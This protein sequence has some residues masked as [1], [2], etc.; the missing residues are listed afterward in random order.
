MVTDFDTCSASGLR[1][2]SQTDC[3]AQRQRVTAQLL[4]SLQPKSKEEQQRQKTQKGEKPDG[5]SSVVKKHCTAARQERS[6]E[7]MSRVKKA[8]IKAVVKA[9]AADLKKGMTTDAAPGAARRAMT[10]HRILRAGR[11]VGREGGCT[12][13]CSVQKVPG[14]TPQRWEKI[15]SYVGRARPA[16]LKRVKAENS[17]GEED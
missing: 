2:F 8:D 11:C 14:G 12:A 17:I 4:Q 6:E 1:E 7:E 15:A 9:P 13:A 5:G 3:K 16:V 10:G